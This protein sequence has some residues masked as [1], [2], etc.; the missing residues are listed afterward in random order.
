MAQA[1]TLAEQIAGST[2][3]V[4]PGGYAIVR[5]DR[6]RLPESGFLARKC[7]AM[8]S[9]LEADEI[10]LVVESAA[11]PSVAD[12]A[13]PLHSVYRAIRVNPL[14]PFEGVGFISAVSGAIAEEGVNILAVSAY[15][16]DY[17]LVK[18]GDFAASRDAL[19]R[20]GMTEAGARPRRYSD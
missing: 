14:V 17:F 4:L 2:Y 9:D 13:Y 20:L 6:A 15:S 8:I 12:P 11:A 3:S 16:F 7:F 19:R 18:E 10:T 1:V 5:V